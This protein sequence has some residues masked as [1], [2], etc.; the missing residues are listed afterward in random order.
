[1]L[2]ATFVVP[3][4]QPRVEKNT[5][6]RPVL[7]SEAPLV[8][9]GQPRVEKKPVARPVL[10]AETSL[11]PMREIEIADETRPVASLAAIRRTKGSVSVSTEPQVL[12]AAA[13]LEAWAGIAEAL[14]TSVEIKLSVKGADGRQVVRQIAPPPGGLVTPRWVELDLDLKDLVGQKVGFE[15]SI[16]AQGVLPTALVPGV[17]RILVRRAAPPQAR[18]IVLISLDT[19]RADRLGIYGN[20]RDT[21]PRLDALAREGGRVQVALAAAS[22]TPP[23]HMTML[24]GTSP[25]RHGVFGIYAEDDLPDDIETLAGRLARQGWTTGAITEDAYVGAPFGFARG[26]DSYREFKQLVPVGNQ[27][28]PRLNTP[29]GYGPRTFRAAQAWI[30][31]N[32]D[33]LFFLFVHTYQMHG[34]R[35]PEPPFDGLFP[36]SIEPGQTDRHA[37]FHDLGRYDGLLRQSDGLVGDLLDTIKGLGL[38]RDTLVVVTSDHGEAFFEHGTAGH[39]HAAFEEE[40]RVPLLFRAPGLIPARV[41]AGPVGLVDLVPTLLELV[42]AEPTVGLDGESFAGALLRGTPLSQTRALYAEPAPGA[43]R[44]VRDGR[45]KILRQVSS[46]E[47]TVF[48]LGRDPQE[49]AGRSFGAFDDLAAGERQRLQALRQTLD[50]LGEA[51]NDRR[52][53]SDAER[54]GDTQLDQAR[55]EKLRALGYLR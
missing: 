38:E 5:V 18:N 31:N 6:A 39:G 35:R 14:P 33:R 11:Q 36:S 32:A 40:L 3:T 19:L 53:R 45:W 44:T 21:S 7:S 55:T 52:R 48:D 15:L 41:V 20:A 16:S 22:S 10:L 23:S 1:M 4:G 24:T 34:P 26:F 27:V 47:D 13:R 8:P 25:C 9:T 28:S 46:G 50:T 29:T 42:G 51:C 54:Q 49:K 37:E 12:P 2:S 43:V 17:P 30:E